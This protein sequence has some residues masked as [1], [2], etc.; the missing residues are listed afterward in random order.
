[1]KA[2]IMFV[3]VIYYANVVL[4]CSKQCVCRF[5][6]KDVIIG[7]NCS[8]SELNELPKLIGDYEVI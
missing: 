7:V 5:N 6:D 8:N 2:L 3:I 4:A 1:M